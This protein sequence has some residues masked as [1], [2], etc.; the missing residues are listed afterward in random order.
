MWGWQAE[1]SK[2]RFLGLSNSGSS[3]LLFREQYRIA[4]GQDPWAVRLLSGDSAHGQEELLL[5]QTWVE[6]KAKFK[7]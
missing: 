4:W 3:A 2:E 5:L 1:E 7:A 6:S